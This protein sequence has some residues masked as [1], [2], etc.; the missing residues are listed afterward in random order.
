MQAFPIMLVIPP[1]LLVEPS[2]IEE[3]FSTCWGWKAC[4]EGALS[5]GF[6]RFLDIT[7]C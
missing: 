4:L 1:L 7:S 5:A 3:A 2:W 6:M